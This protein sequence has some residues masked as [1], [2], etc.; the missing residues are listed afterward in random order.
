[1][2]VKNVL[3]E[4]VIPIKW[5]EDYRKKLELQYNYVESNVIKIMIEKWREENERMD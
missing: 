3:T 5:I 4:K 1:M 2:E